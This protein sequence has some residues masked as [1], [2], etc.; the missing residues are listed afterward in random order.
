MMDFDPV[1][2]GCFDMTNTEFYAAAAPYVAV[3]AL[4]LGIGVVRVVAGR[5][6]CVLLDL[7]R[8]RGR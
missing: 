8:R 3:Y 2:G 5:K 4:M 7:S 1:W 6:P